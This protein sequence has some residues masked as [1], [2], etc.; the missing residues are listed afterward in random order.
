MLKKT[1]F[2]Y[3]ENYTLYELEKDQNVQA[4]RSSLA[5]ERYDIKNGL[6]EELFKIFSVEEVF[7][8]PCT[9]MRGFYCFY[10]TFIRKNH[11]CLIK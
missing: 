3:N 2:L 9:A 8:V 4:H 10:S 6:A 1:Q 7:P 5:M 11:R